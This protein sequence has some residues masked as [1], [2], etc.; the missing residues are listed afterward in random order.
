MPWLLKIHVSITRGIAFVHVE[1]L[2]G[3]SVNE[4]SHTPVIPFIEV[5]NSV[6]TDSRN[7]TLASIRTEHAIEI[8]RF[9]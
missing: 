3:Y 4:Y 5:I 1:V 2:D 7:I 6:R 9:L 8:T